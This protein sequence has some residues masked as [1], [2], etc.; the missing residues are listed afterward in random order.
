MHSGQLFTPRLRSARMISAAL[1][2][3]PLL[4]PVE[5]MAAQLLRAGSGVLIAA[6]AVDKALA[7]DRVAISAGMGERVRMAGLDLHAEGQGRALAALSSEFLTIAVTSGRF[8]FGS[9]PSAGPGQALLVA[10][11]G[12]RVQRLA[13]DARHLSATLSPAARPLLGADLERLIRAQRRARFFGSYE[14]LRVNARSPAP[15]ATETVRT[16]YLSDPAV[17]R[18]RRTSVGVASA[19]AR[20][21]QVADAFL[22]AFLAGDQPTVAS[23]LDPAPFL[24][25]GGE[26]GVDEGRRDAAAALFADRALVGGL[27]GAELTSVAGDGRSAML[28]SPTMQWR[29]ALV[30]R[31]RAIFVAGLEPAT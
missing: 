5:A 1:L 14:P 6:D 28:R 2:L 24:L 10:L 16:S 19:E 25:L 7:E 4:P 23:L 21:R 11:D 18:Q 30:Q 27:A 20:S 31:D 26:A 17:V 3:C 22:A 13:F 15:P 29:L 12:D 8:R 9:G